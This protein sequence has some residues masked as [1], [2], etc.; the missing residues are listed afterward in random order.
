MI[1]GQMLGSQK[2][3]RLWDLELVRVCLTTAHVSTSLSKTVA[4]KN[5]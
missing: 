1:P 5:S 2:H 4:L 3:D